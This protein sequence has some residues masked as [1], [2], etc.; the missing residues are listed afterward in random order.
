MRLGNAKLGRFMSPDNFIQDP[1][2]TQSFNRYSYVWNNPLRYNDPSGELAFLAVVAIGAAIG[3]IGNGVK[4]AINGQCLFKGAFKAAFIGA[5]SA[6]IGFGVANLAGGVGFFSSKLVTTGF[7]QGF[8]VGATGGFAGGFVGGALGSWMNGGNLRDGI[9]SGI[10]GGVIGGLTG[11]LVGGITA[12]VRARK[13]GLD[14]WSGN[15]TMEMPFDNSLA[16]MGGDRIEYSN[17]SAKA[18][19][20]SHSELKRLGTNASSLNADGS[21]PI[22]VKG[23]MYTSDGGI[24]KR[25]NLETGSSTRINGVT[26]F[27]GGKAHVYLSKS[28]FVNSKQLY[29]TMHHEYMH[30]YFGMNNIPLSS[31]GQHQVIHNWQHDQANIWR[32]MSPYSELLLRSKTKFLTPGLNYEAFGFR[33]I[34]YLP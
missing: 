16:A 11:G 29:M 33:T 19:S 15:G 7:A 26:H 34:N 23:K 2:N 12:G 10:K 25:Y 4:N 9:S 28:V 5:V 8:V 18:F 1:Y 14:F 22:G 17:K 21:Y 31:S 13:M 27:H 30:A 3:V 24:L 20:D 6:A 32:R